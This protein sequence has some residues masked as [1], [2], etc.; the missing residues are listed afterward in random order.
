MKLI[1][2]FEPSVKD[3]HITKNK[4]DFD[5]KIHNTKSNKDNFLGKGHFSAAY[6]HKNDPHMVNK[7]SHDR[8]FGDIDLY[9]Q[10]VDRIIE[11][12]VW[13]SNPHFPRFYSIKKYNTK[14]GETL[15]KGTMEKLIS[16]KEIEPELLKSYIENNLFKIYIND[17]EL[18]GHSNSDAVLI[19]LEEL[20]DNLLSLRG[21]YSPIK[22]KKLIEALEFIDSSCKKLKYC[23]LDIK[24][25]NIM[26]RRTNYGIDIVFTDPLAS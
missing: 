7:I 21:N 3:I 18:E 11:S 26:F 12:G 22:N 6:D 14:S 15:Y 4:M 24:P 16:Y 2:L 19:Y 9:W 5:D 17:S 8:S 1:E 25:D 10:Y 20:C 13:K 23:F